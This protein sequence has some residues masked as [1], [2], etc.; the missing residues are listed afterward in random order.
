MLAKITNY[1]ITS[2]KKV[3]KMLQQS[4]N[5]AIWG[6]IATIC[7]IDALAE[8]TEKRMNSGCAKKKSGCALQ[9]LLI[10]IFTSHIR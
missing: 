4:I 5:A 1:F 2:E 10:L 7:T 9:P 8:L 3:K 6:I